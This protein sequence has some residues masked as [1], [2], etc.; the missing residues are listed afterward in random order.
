[1][2]I[3]VTAP[4]D[5]ALAELAAHLPEDIGEIIPAGV[6]GAGR[7]LLQ[8]AVPRGIKV[9]ELFVEYEEFGPMALLEHFMRAIGSADRVI[10][11][12]DGSLPDI[13]RYI[14][15]CGLHRKPLTVVD[16]E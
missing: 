5:I 3:A 16:M 6:W 10:I 13:D 14:E 4:S 12:R 15:Q 2:K 7:S 11:F 9:T 1:M 8:Y